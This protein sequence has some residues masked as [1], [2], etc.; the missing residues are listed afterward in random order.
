MVHDSDAG[1]RMK[2]T[3]QILGVVATAGMFIVLVM[4]ATVTNTGSEHGCGKSWPLCHGQWIPQF[5]VRTFI[6]FSHRAVVAGETVL[7][8]ALAVGAVYLYRRRRS[9]QLLVPIMVL[10]LFLQAGL[11]AW[12]VM[13]PTSA[14]IL[15]LHFGVSLVAFASVLLTTVAVFQADLAMKPRLPQALRNFVFLLA[16]Y[17]Y[18]VVYLG[19]YVR[20]TNAD[21][22]CSGWP[23]CNGAVIP[24][25]HGNVLI[26]FSHRF[27]AG[28]LTLA[29]VGLVVWCRR[30]RAERPDVFWGSIAALAAVILQVVA[31]AAIVFT[32]MD[33]FSALAHA[34]LAGVLF[35]SLSYIWMQTL[36]AR[37]PAVGRA[38]SQTASAADA[39]IIG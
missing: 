24:F 28:I 1:Q 31:G 18:V 19:A 39:L 4:G 3:V 11:G 14:P 25:L 12:A 13:N 15:A 29:V 5:A 33:I 10:F 9:I 7:I 23:L 27:A 34:A 21:D 26:V 20:H 8:L 2:K 17:T 36:T 22:A 32:D 37:Q 6:E 30:Y 35:S 16:G 38:Y